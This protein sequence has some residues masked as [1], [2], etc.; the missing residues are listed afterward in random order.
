MPDKPSDQPELQSIYN[1]LVHSEDLAT[2]GQPIETE[3]QAI[4]QYGF[5]V[6]IN[7][8]L[9]NAEYSLPNE[10]ELVTS[11]GMAYEHIPVSWE[12]PTTGD[13]KVFYQTMRRWQNR[14]VFLH[15]AAN[16]R[17]SI[18][19]AL[20]RI[21]CLGWPE[22]QASNDIKRIWEPNSVWKNFFEIHKHQAA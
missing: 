11:L 21:N 16:K 8:A 18:F 2:A 3:L 14:K 22:H 20:Y 12:N 19:L 10:Q 6:V 15:C 4:S 5:D 13:L 7:L 17:V 1:V 9:E